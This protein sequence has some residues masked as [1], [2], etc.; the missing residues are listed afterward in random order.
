MRFLTA[1]ES[2]GQALYGIIEGLPSGLKVDLGV[3]DDMLVRRQHVPGRGVRSKNIDHAEILSGVYGGVTTGAPIAVKIQNVGGGEKPNFDFYRPGHVDLV[4]D[5]KYC[6]NDPSLGAERASARETAMRTAL[7]GICVLLLRE[8]GITLSSN[9]L[10]IGKESNSELFE[11][12]IEKAEKLGETLGGKLRVTASGVITGVGSHVFYDRRLDGKIAGALMSIPSVKAVELGH[13]VRFTEFYGS[14]AADEIIK[15]GDK[16]RRTHNYCGGIEGGI[17]DG[18]DITFSLTLKPV[19]SVVEVRTIDSLGG[20]RLTG[21]TRGD[22]CAVFAACVVAEAVVALE[23]C[24]AILECLGGDTM[25]ELKR[26]YAVKG[27]PCRR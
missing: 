20:E 23:L 12:E 6:Y 10:Q 22:V 11:A 7:G 27:E 18:E 17:S 24:S 1:G 4:A 8:L 9:V 26:R 21:K 16:I 13:G 3:I 5:K 19:P 14:Q 15:D 2:H 25:E